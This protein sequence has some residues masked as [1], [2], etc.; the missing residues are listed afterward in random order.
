MPISARADF[1][2]SSQGQTY[3]GSTT[4]NAD[5]S[6]SLNINATGKAA[7]IGSL[8]T[9]TD[10]TTGTL[11][12]TA[13]HGIITADRIDIYWTGGSRQGVT[14]GTVATNSV[15]FSGGAGDN[16]PI[17]T[18]AVVAKVAQNEEFL[19]TGANAQSIFFYAVNRSIVVLTTSVP[20]NVLVMV[21]PAGGI[22]AWY[23]GNGVTNPVTGSAIARCY[24][25]QDG[26]LPA[27]IR[28]TVLYN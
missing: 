27:N 15:P 7:D 12:M 11:T 9:R 3:V 4:I 21:I 10:N 2:Y 22:Y 5:K 16:L 18:T 14:V 23:N 1:T 25:S 13:G 26:V 24:V 28:G 20:A 19:F 8:S 17:A 6:Q